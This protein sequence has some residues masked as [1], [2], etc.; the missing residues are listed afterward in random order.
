MYEK[1]SI[2]SFWGFKAKSQKKEIM[3]LFR[4]WSRIQFSPYVIGQMWLRSQS[5]KAE[6]GKGGQCWICLGMHSITCHNGHLDTSLHITTPQNSCPLTEGTKRR[7]VEEK[8]TSCRR[9]SRSTIGMSCPLKSVSVLFSWVVMFLCG[10]LPPKCDFSFIFYSEVFR[11]QDFNFEDLELEDLDFE[12]LYNQDFDFEN[13]Q[14]Q[15]LWFL[16]PSISKTLISR[17]LISKVSKSKF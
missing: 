14:F 11:F 4:T 10:I 17:T 16:G 6:K 9:E 13:L 12:D 7:R 3:C 15:G 2:E 1:W 8:I 5:W